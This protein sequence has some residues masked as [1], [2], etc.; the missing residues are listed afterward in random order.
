MVPTF[1]CGLVRSNFFLAILLS[2]G[3]RPFHPAFL[4]RFSVSPPRGSN[5]RPRP[6][7]GR[8]LPTE[9]GGQSS[10]F[11]TRK[12][13]C[14]A[15]LPRAAGSRRLSACLPRRVKERPERRTYGR[16]RKVR[17][18]P[19]TVPG[20]LVRVTAKELP[21]APSVEGCAI[22]WPA[23]LIIATA[24]APRALRLCVLP[25]RTALPAVKR[26]VP[27]SSSGMIPR[28]ALGAS[29]IHSADER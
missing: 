26:T 25:S 11:R 5:P 19:C 15:Q 18:P 3:L 12:E 29:W 2:Q 7:Q 6:Y 8:A 27:K 24:V 16:R 10:F 20:A 21:S 9:L 4:F 1:T 28:P 14:L 17:P 22:A 13:S 23:R